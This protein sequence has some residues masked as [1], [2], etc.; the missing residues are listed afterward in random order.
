MTLK[1]RHGVLNGCFKVILQKRLEVLQAFRV[2]MTAARD[3][4]EILGLTGGPFQE[5]LAVNRAFE[6]SPLASVVDRNGDAFSKTLG[7]PPLS[8]S[9][10]RSLAREVYFI[11]PLLGVLRG[12]DLVPDYRCP[13]G[14]NLPRI[15]SLHRFW[16]VPVSATLNRLLKGAQVFSFL[17]ARLSAL[18]EPDGREA[19]ITAI[20][21]SRKSED[22]CCGE[23]AA[24]PRLS[25][26]AVRFILENDVRSAGDMMKFKSSAGHSYSAVRSTDRGR[27]RCLNMVLD[28]ARAS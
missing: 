19:G 15:G 21:F 10:R 11:C 14:A 16:K 7:Q 22:S 4:Q 13:V 12:D 27:V 20:R 6:T 25:A 23:T 8:A 1:T 26:E 3:A 5:A 24:V 17:P 28:P 18:W 2:G 9:A